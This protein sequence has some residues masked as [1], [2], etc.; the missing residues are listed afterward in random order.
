M[1]A[2]PLHV[3]SGSSWV[4]GNERRLDV[5]R[6]LLQFGADI[7]ARDDEGQTPFMGAAAIDNHKIKQLLSEHGA[8]DDID[9]RV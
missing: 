8:E 3:A 1:N 7:H 4:Y 6:L 9:H 5:V 2:T